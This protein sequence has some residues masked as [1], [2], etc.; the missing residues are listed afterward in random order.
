[1]TTRK[2]DLR[3]PSVV[4]L[5]VAAS[6]RWIAILD[7]AGI[8]RK[9]LDGR[10]H[11]CPLCD[12][13][14]R[15]AAFS[16]VRERGAVHCRHCFTSGCNPCPSDGIATLQ[17]ILQ[18]DFISA[19]KWLAD[20]LGLR[21]QSNGKRSSK[22]IT[23]VVRSTSAVIKMEPVD[24]TDIAALASK[25]HTSM[26]PDLWRSFSEILG[27]PIECLQRMRVGWS[28]KRDAMTWP[29]VDANK[30]TVGIRLR[31]LATGRKWSVRGGSAGVFV[32]TDLLQ[33]I[34]RLYATE[35]P[36]DTAALLSL[37]LP[38]IGRSSAHGK[39]DI[40]T[41]TVRRLKPE[42]C[43]IVADRDKVGQQG[44]TQFANALFLSCRVVR[45]LT[46]PE[47]FAD[48][49]EWVRSGIAKSD[50]IDAVQQTKAHSLQLSSEVMI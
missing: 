3:Y 35:G 38:A 27:L 19:C 37:G 34:D 48:A 40:D 23:R 33:P 15:F 20:W 49:R 10:G 1:M 12:G 13:E 46:P 8:R 28:R 21:W 6:G 44:A 11:P 42:E 17:W 14:D 22:Q 29:M 45:I 41:A 16:D 43:V 24:Q 47:E 31:S 36:T 25:C 50:V 18:T 7:E 2:N 30:N 32:P 26:T 4:E 9:L 5:K 39:L